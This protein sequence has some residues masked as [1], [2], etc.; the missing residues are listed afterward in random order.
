MASSPLPASRARALRAPPALRHLLLE[1]PPHRQRATS[2]ALPARRFRLE[3]AARA[4]TARQSAACPGFASKGVRQRETRA[5]CHVRK[6]LILQM[7][8]CRW[9]ALAAQRPTRAATHAFLRAAAARPPLPALHTGTLLAR[10]RETQFA[11]VRKASFPIRLQLVYHSAPTPLPLIS[12][13]KRLRARPALTGKRPMAAPRV[14]AMTA[15]LAPFPRAAST[16][17]KS[18]TTQTPWQTQHPTRATGARARASRAL[19]RTGW[20]ECQPARSAA[21]ECG[22][23]WAM[24]LARSARREPS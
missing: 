12:R 6:G 1:W 22:R 7:P 20:G 18:A 23:E 19:L 4:Q 24:R 9:P 2:I 16:R 15:R 14:R 13:A 11:A 3:P 8:R 17:A 21:A 5:A 10:P